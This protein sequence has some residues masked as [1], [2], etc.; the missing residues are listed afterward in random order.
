[1]LKLTVE[2]IAKSFGKRKIFENINFALESG[3]SIAIV[4]PNG[5]GK[6]TLVSLLL[7]LLYPSR[8][9][10]VYTE[11]GKALD[12]DKYRKNISLVAPYYSLYEPLTAYENLKF[13]S[14]IDGYNFSNGEI[15][16]VL[17]IVGLGG[18]GDDYVS[19]YSTGMKQRLKYALAIL[20]KTCLWILDEPTVNLDDDGRRIIFDLIEKYRKDSIIVIATNDKEE[21]RL[22]EQICQLGG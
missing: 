17:D 19:A 12:F 4:G 2:N 10:I 18:R 16:K 20:K 8:G 6:T 11:D 3:Q 5:S 15:E 1:M 14:K 22:A 21:Y 7:G 13:F 9:K